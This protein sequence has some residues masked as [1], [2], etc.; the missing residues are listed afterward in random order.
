MMEA[1]RAP[2]SVALPGSIGWRSFIV[3]GNVIAALV[4]F[5]VSFVSF[6]RTLFEGLFGVSVKDRWN[7]LAG[8]QAVSA[9]LCALPDYFNPP[10]PKMPIKA[11]SL[12]ARYCVGALALASGF[13]W[14]LSAT[15][16]TVP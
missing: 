4:I 15:S 3:L 11:P 7:F 16:L 12:P 9:V 10:R 2:A 8:L 14:M 6:I 5:H 13:F 1:L